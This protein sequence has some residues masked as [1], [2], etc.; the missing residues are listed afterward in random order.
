MKRAKIKKAITALVLLIIFLIV[1][2]PLLWSIVMSFDRAATT[3][4]PPFSLWPHKPTMF[5]YTASFKMIDLMQYFKNTVIIVAINTSLAVLFSMMCGFAFAK[6]KFVGKKFW[7]IFMLAVMM[8][9]FESRL[10]PLYLQYRNWKLL[11]TWWPLILG[12]FAYVYGTFF[13]RSYISSIP[14]SLAESVYID[15]GS[16]WRVF[17]SVIVPLSKPIMSTLAILQIISNWNAYLWPLVVIKD[18][19]KQ[20]ISVGVAMFNAQQESFYYGPRMAVSVM[21]AIPLTILY[22]ILQKHIV[23]SIAVSGIKQ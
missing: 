23:A 4:L 2:T 20:M 11:N 21:S 8:V 17:W 15:G 22:L 16:E 5:N 19:S 3:S 14:D 6:L 18:Y 12:Q 1:I 13:A 10:V 9:P 7:F